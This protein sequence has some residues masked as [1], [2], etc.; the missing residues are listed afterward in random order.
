[1]GPE[2]VMQNG[3]Q[4][5]QADQALP[6]GLVEQGSAELPL[7]VFTEHLT[8]IRKELQANGARGN[9]PTFTGEGSGADFVQWA[10]QLEILEVALNATDD[11]MRFQ[12]LQKLSGQAADYAYSLINAEPTLTWNKLQEKRYTHRAEVLYAL[13]RL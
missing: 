10:K 5:Q 8:N 3:V 7:T 11:Q 13:Q 2:G 4:G 6:E 1:M 9:I 12:A